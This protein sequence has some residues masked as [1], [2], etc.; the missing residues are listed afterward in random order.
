M[1]RYQVDMILRGFAEKSKGGSLV[2][3]KKK[4]AE[5]DS[6]VDAKLICLGSQ[7]IVMCLL[8]TNPVVAEMPCPADVRLRQGSNT[9]CAASSS[10]QRGAQGLTRT[11][12]EHSNKDDAFQPMMMQE[13]GNIGPKGPKRCWKCAYIT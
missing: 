7:F 13:T 6:L 12:A 1:K 3:A 5:L 11:N 4:A 8:L 9:N 10:V 2:M